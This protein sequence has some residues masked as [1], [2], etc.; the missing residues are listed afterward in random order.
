MSNDGGKP[1]ETTLA[2][3]SLSTVP[4]P[5]AT[6][7]TKPKMVLLE[8]D[9]RF[10]VFPEFVFYDFAQPVKLPGALRPAMLWFRPTKRSRR[11]PDSEADDLHD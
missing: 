1:F 5:Q 10:A 7:E 6:R 11:L 9:N 2:N 4:H 3:H 8:H